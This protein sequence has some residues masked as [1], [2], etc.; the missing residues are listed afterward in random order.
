MSNPIAIRAACPADLPLLAD[1]AQAMALETEAKQ[2]DRATVER[3]LR[4]VFER[5]GLAEYWVAEHNGRVVG[6]L[7]LTYEWSDWRDGLWWWIQSVYVLPK[8]RRSGVFKTL[9]Q[10]VRQRCAADPA[11]C[12]LRLYVEAQN[13]K[14]QATYR[15]LG[16]ADAH[17]RVME[18]TL[19][20]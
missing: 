9:Y 3:G 5:P 18:E 6:C 7:M 13:L 20:R 11:A 16:M 10:H 15:A 19:S 14:A 12:G 17:Y 1:F 4:A 8:A 2:L